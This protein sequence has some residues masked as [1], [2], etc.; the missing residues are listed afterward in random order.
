MEHSPKIF[1]R[2][3]KATTTTIIN[4]SV[5]RD[6]I[7]RETPFYECELLLLSCRGRGRAEDATIPM[8][9]LNTYVCYY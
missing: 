6:E 9:D 3:E 2:E 4:V 7:F 1:A 8:I 5:K